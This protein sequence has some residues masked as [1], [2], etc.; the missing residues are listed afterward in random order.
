M[1][2]GYTVEEFKDA[3]KEELADRIKM[4]MGA[5]HPEILS[6]RFLGQLAD[7]AAVEA[8]EFFYVPEEVEDK[9]LTGAERYLNGRL[10]D[11]EYKATFDSVCERLRGLTPWK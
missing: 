9:D 5:A 1:T 3:L 10:D 6:G 2:L 7:E 4:A 8:L 11:P